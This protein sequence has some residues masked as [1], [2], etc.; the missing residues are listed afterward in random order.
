MAPTIRD[1][2]GQKNAT[3]VVGPDHVLM[4]QNEVTTVVEGSL[5]VS[6]LRIL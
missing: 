1:A 4:T 2:E 3:F 6:I 5:E